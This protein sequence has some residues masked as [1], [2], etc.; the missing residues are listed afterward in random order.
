MKEFDPK[1]IKIKTV[2][3]NA[4]H[5]DSPNFL[6]EE[7]RIVLYEEDIHGIRKVIIP[8]HAVVSYILLAEENKS[9]L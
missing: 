9:N 6:V 5:A 8:M 4:F 1:G 3:G 2:N 7:D